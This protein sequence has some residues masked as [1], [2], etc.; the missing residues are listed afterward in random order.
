M[1]DHQIIRWTSIELLHN[2][3]RQLQSALDGGYIDALPTIHYRGKVKLHGT[4]AGIQIHPDGTVLAQGRNHVLDAEQTNMGFATWV[5]DQRAAFA[6]LARPGRITVVYGEWCGPGIQRK[7]AITQVDRRV[8]AVF[9]VQ[10]TDPLAEAAELIVA[11]EAIDELL[12]NHPDVF[13]LPWHGARFAMDFADEAQLEAQA[14][15][16]A[17]QVVAVEQR[18]PWVAETFGVEGVGEGLVL[19]PVPEAEHELGPRPRRDVTELLWKAKGVKHKVTRSDKVVQ[20][21]P[22]IVASVAAFADLFVT[23]QRLE[24]GLVEVFGSERPT[25][26]GI[27]PFLRW[28]GQDVKKESVA[29][30]EAADLTWKQVA[31]AVNTRAK[32]WLMPRLPR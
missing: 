12:P 9:A 14:D 6:Q 1:T 22:L 8:F 20:I 3:R 7:V 4:N 2:V 18:D 27:G 21:D 25:H 10:Y 31:K 26:Q 11:P 16:V 29:E 5:A 28:F 15:R 32:T 17:E 19:F 23:E 24:Q 13:T 30:L